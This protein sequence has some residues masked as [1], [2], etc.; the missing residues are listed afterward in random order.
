[1]PIAL[2]HGRVDWSVPPSD[3]RCQ[4]RPFERR[5]GGPRWTHGGTGWTQ[6]VMEDGRLRELLPERG[7]RCTLHLGTVGRLRKQGRPSPASRGTRTL[8]RERK[9][10]SRARSALRTGGAPTRP[11][12]EAEG[13]DAPVAAAGTVASGMGGA[14]DHAGRQGHGPA[15]SAEPSAPPSGC[16]RRSRSSTQSWQATPYPELSLPGME[17]A[18]P[19]YPRESLRFPRILW[20]R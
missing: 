5:V 10:P 15:G 4:D 6:I 18:W 19:K 14:T 11:A 8:S 13:V 7:E 17:Q 20:G 1:M 9:A 3:S 16:P 12:G 2:L